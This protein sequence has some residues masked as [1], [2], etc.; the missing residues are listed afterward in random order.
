LVI[1]YLDIGTAL[2]ILLLNSIVLIPLLY[3]TKFF[4]P[5]FED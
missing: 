1:L 3:S 5:I 2:I 4:Y